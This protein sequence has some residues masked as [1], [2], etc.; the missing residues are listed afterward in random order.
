VPGVCSRAM[1]QLLSPIESSRR[2]VNL[3]SRFSTLASGLAS[4]VCRARPVNGP[5]EVYGC[6]TVLTVLS[7]G[8]SSER[9][10][11]AGSEPRQ[12]E[13]EGSPGQGIASP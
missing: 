12:H 5:R 11:T 6:S 8:A 1:R 2:A 9:S 10:T 3:E 13:A 4:S 7:L